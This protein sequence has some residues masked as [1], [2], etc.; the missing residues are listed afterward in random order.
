MKPTR[1]GFIKTLAIGIIGKEVLSGYPIGAFAKT[2]IYDDGIEI[3]K[4][5][6][7]FNRETQKSMEALA[8][9]LLP[10]AKQIGIKALFMEYISKDHGIAGYLDAG[11][12]NLDT[13]STAKFKKPF[14]KLT[15]KE[16]KKSVIDHVSRANR[17]FFRKFR[18]TIIRLYYSNPAV[19]K[20]LSYSGPPQPRGFMN[21]QLPPVN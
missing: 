1:R 4:G 18:Y 5:Y 13:I 15:S 11:I 2:N 17:Q 20:R 10:G 12:W 21:Y 6:K 3:Q 14:Y 7:V 19:W 16:E 8:D 9:T